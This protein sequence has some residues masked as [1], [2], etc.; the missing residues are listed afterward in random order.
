MTETILTYCVR[1][2]NCPRCGVKKGEFCIF[3]SGGKA[4]KPHQD[5]IKLVSKEERTKIMLEILERI[6]K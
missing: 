3:P 6:K 4:L 2:Y 1:N 5:R